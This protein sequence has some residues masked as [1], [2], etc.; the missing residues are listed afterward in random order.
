MVKRFLI[1]LLAFSFMLSGCVFNEPSETTNTTDTSGDAQETTDTTEVKVIEVDEITEEVVSFITFSLGIS[2]G[3]GY[4]KTGIELLFSFPECENAVIRAYADGG[5]LLLH[6][7]V[8]DGP[9]E[10]ASTAFEMENGGRVTWRSGNLYPSA[11]EQGVTGSGYH[12]KNLNPQSSDE[13]SNFEGRL[14][15]VDMIV[16]DGELIVGYAVCK[17][18]DRTGKENPLEFVYE[19]E[20]VKSVSFPQ[21]DGKYQKVSEEYVLE[22]IEQLKSK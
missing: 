6:T 10:V 12:W 13:R 2:W 9:G 18:Q 19:A 5:W 22:Q 11:E 15:Y 4:G 14:A 3:H 7:G 16:Y 8:F 1:L 17:L 21:I 20:I